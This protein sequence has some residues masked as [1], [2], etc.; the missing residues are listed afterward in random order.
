MTSYKI[1]DPV[2]WYSYIKLHFVQISLNDSFRSHIHAQSVHIAKIHE[3]VQ[4]TKFFHYNHLKIAV[5]YKTLD[6]NCL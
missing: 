1:I 4:Q 6:N 2:F 5:K 3:Y